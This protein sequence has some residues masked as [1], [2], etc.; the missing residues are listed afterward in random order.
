MAGPNKAKQ[1][2]AAARK[3]KVSVADWAAT[4]PSTRPV[5]CAVCAEPDVREAVDEFCAIHARRE[6]HLSFTEFHKLYLVGEMGWQFSYEAMMNHVRHHAG[7][8]R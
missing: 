1:T 5:R 8:S 4:T 2:R 6:T 3:A 7:G